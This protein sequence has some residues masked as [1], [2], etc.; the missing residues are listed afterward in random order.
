MACVEANYTSNGPSAA[1]SICACRDAG[2][3]GVR[4]GS[5]GGQRGVR[6]EAEAGQR[7]NGSLSTSTSSNQNAGF[8][9]TPPRKWR[10][11]ALNKGDVTR[12]GDAGFVRSHI[13]NCR[14]RLGHV[15]AYAHHTRNIRRTTC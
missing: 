2:R 4:G 11:K 13:T 15:G 3:R 5:A 1:A 8:S 14:L 10:Q 9:P 12:G 6:G 7:G